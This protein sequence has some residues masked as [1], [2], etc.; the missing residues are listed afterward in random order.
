MHEVCRRLGNEL[1]S[2][3]DSFC[4]FQMP[5]SLPHQQIL[6]KSYVKLFKTVFIVLIGLMFSKRYL[7][8]K[9]L[10]IL[11]LR[12]EN[13]IAAEKWSDPVSHKAARLMIKKDYLKLVKCVLPYHMCVINQ[14]E[15][16]WQT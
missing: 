1:T 4:E 15:C 14:C 7:L 5:L 9:R 3:D 10:H 13:I 6:R 11:I 12:D 8:F 2:E 16:V